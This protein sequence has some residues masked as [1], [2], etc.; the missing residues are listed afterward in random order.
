[1]GVAFASLKKL[2][3]EA[4]AKF[5]C[6]ITLRLERG[7]LVLQYTFSINGKGGRNLGIR[8]NDSLVGVSIQPPS[9]AVV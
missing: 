2:G 4:Y 6:D 7:G 9:P 1:M 3:V 8:L 5:S